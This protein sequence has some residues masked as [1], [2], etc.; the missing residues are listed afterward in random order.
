MK[1]TLYTRYSLRVLIYLAARPGSLVPIS[2]IARSDG[3]P[4]NHLAK[5]V[6]D[7]RKAGLLDAVRGRAGGIRLARP[8]KD[9]GVG[10]IVRYAE[11]GHGPGERGCRTRSACSLD[12]VMDEAWQ[13][14]MESLDRYTLADLVEA[15]QQPSRVTPDSPA[16]N[17]PS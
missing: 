15:P 13:A 17:E 11:K 14:F 10:Y 5:I 4:H 16:S 2:E 6:Q 12:G 1:L 9:I 3:I 7:L 8:A